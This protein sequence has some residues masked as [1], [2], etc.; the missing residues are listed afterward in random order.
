MGSRAKETEGEKPS[1]PQ[2]PAFQTPISLVGAAL[3]PL[4]L[5]MEWHGSAGQPGTPASR[6]GMPAS[7][8]SG[9]VLMLGLEG[10]S[11]SGTGVPGTHRGDLHRV[12]GSGFSL[13]QPKFLQVDG[14]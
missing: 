11:G 4:A 8:S 10:S 9:I 5:G 12:P 13:I 7:R 6:T 2:Q 14:E 3:L 1:G